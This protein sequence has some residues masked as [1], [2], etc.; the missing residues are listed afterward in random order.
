MLGSILMVTHDGIKIWIDPK[1]TEAIAKTPIPTMVTHVRSCLGACECTHIPR[2]ATVSEPLT[3]LTWKNVPFVWSED[4]QS[5]FDMLKSSMIH[6]ASLVPFDPEI[7]VLLR[8]DTSDYGLRACLFMI[9][10][11]ESLPVSFAARTLSLAE[12]NYSTKENEA[13]AAVWV[14]DKQFSKYLLGIHFTIESDQSSLTTLLF[15]HSARA[16]QWIQRWTEWLR[17]YHFTPQHIPGKENSI[18]DFLSRRNVSF[19]HKRK[20]T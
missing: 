5:A 19:L 3:N 17:K 4:C 13:L 16:S 14:I 11:G 20:L 6:A 9:K 10:D 1:K 15:Q 7:P 2:F 8:T 12:H 18:S